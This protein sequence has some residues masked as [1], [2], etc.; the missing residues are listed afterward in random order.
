M[1]FGTEDCSNQPWRSRKQVSAADFSPTTCERWPPRTCTTSSK[2]HPFVEGN[3]RIGLATALAFL[4]NNGIVIVTGTDE[5]YETTIA[6]A[7]GRLT[8][9]QVAENLRNLRPSAS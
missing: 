9:D 3:K 2:N 7:D 6:V 5:L 1:E 4:E 8:K